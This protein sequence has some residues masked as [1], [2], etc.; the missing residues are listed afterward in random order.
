MRKRA[1]CKCDDQVTDATSVPPRQP[2]HGKARP[3]P[4]TGAGSDQPL[5]TQRRLCGRP[6][7][8]PR[9]QRKRLR[10]GR[11]V[12]VQRQPPAEDGGDIGIGLGE[13]GAEPIAFA[14]RHH[15]L[16]LAQTPLHP[17]HHHRPRLLGHVRGEQP[18][19]GGVQVR[20]EAERLV[21]P[22]P[23]DRAAGWL[24][25][26]DLRQIAKIGQDRRVLGQHRAV[27]KLKRRHRTARVDLE[28]IAPA[29]GHL[30][31]QVDRLGLEGHAHLAQ[32]DM[33]GERTGA[34]LVVEF[35]RPSSENRSC[36]RCSSP[37]RRGNGNRPRIAP[38]A[39]TALASLGKV[40]RDLPVAQLVDRARAREGG[41]RLL[42]QA[43][44]ERVDRRRAVVDADLDHRG[45]VMGEGTVE[46]RADLVGGLDI[47]PQKAKRRRR[48]GIARLHALRFQHCRLHVV[49]VELLP[50]LDPAELAVVD[51]HV[52]DPLAILR[53]RRKFAHG[54]GKGAVARDG[55]DARIGPHRR[56]AD[57]RGH[58]IAKPALPAREQE[59]PPRPLRRDVT[60]DPARRE[61]GV[62]D[63]DIL[64]A[65]P[66]RDLGHHPR[67]LDRHPVALD[68]GALVGVAGGLHLGDA[69][70]PLGMGGDLGQRRVDRR[71]RLAH[72]AEQGHRR[73]EG[74]AMFERVG[75]DG[76]RRLLGQRQR[77]VH[78]GV[79]ADLGAAPDHQIGLADKIDRRLRA[80]RVQHPRRIVAGLGNRALARERGDDQPVEPVGEGRHL[81]R[82]LRSMHATAAHERRPLRA[83]DQRRGAGDLAMRGAAAQIGDLPGAVV[84]AD[85]QH[86]LV[87]FGIEDVVRDDQ[88]HRPRPRRGGDA[89]G[90]AD[91]LGQRGDRGHEE[92]LLGAG[93]EEGELV[94]ALARDA[95]L[96]QRQPVERQL[97][98][99][100]DHRDRGV[101]RLEEA[102]GQQV[103][104]GAHR[105]VADPGLAGQPRIGVGGI[106]G[107]AFVAHQDVADAVGAAR[108]P[109]M[110]RRGLPAGH[111]VDILDPVLRQHFR[112]EV[113]DMSHDLSFRQASLGRAAAQGAPRP[114][115]S[116]VVSE[117]WPARDQAGTVAGG[118]A[119]GAGLARLRA[120]IRCISGRSAAWVSR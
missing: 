97:A 26:R 55:D 33:G 67:R 83:P 105:D 60:R 58:R 72:I 73:A 98:D 16:E 100:A 7:H 68:L 115:G 4:R 96:L 110:Q 2:E 39:A 90:G 42:A 106:G 63:H 59:L 43:P 107:V 19:N 53:L 40:G 48:P 112:N 79:L 15:R 87:P 31:L 95:L 80:E 84:D 28:V 85:L 8:H 92:R 14:R 102:R 12:E 24:Q 118:S 45:A 64:G 57:R 36:A 86:L 22:G 71:H 41:V 75:V 46:R 69:G 34:G 88:R 94:E 74:A 103:R 109:V 9:A 91:Q 52:D 116:K 66:A 44:L 111:A 5:G 27:I 37:A 13:I 65:E 104:A 10:A 47:D 25:R 23:R 20:A 76:D 21:Q 89:E 119:T 93:L 56:R 81:G 114:A 54:I 32:H 1:P 101:Q 38:E 99:D 3:V 120:A 29:G 50:E 17:R 78:A 18:A 30:A 82:G 70:A 113:T 108:D 6:R 11:H 77:P 62:R 117:W 49:E 51:D 61:R 35:H